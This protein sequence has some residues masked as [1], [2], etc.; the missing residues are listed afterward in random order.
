MTFRKPSPAMVVAIVALVMAGTGSAIAAVNFARNAGAVDHKSA[1]RATRSPD[2][3]AGKLV[4]TRKSG[5]S[6]GKIPNKFL[7]QVPFASTFSRVAAVED[8]LAG[9]TTPISTTSLG[10]LTAA[11]ND[12]SNQ[13]GNEDP[14]TTVTF[15]N[16]QPVPVNYSRTVGQQPPVIVSQP[17]GT[18]QAF[19]INGSNVFR[20]AVE[21]NGV[22]AVFEGQVRQDGRNTPTGSCLV[23]GTVETFTP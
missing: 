14:T 2:F 10:L 1:V 9:A 16:N 5:K 4:A 6:K 7:G 19:T 11:C 13:T 22:D 23:A 3:A 20:I 12:Q 15:L 21:L 18:Q 17:P 8:N